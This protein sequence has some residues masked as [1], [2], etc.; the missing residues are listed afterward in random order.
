VKLE[1]IEEESFIEDEKIR[2]VQESY[3]HRNPLNQSS[4]DQ[5]QIGS[6]MLIPKF[7]TK[8]MVDLSDRSSQEN[9]LVCQEH[10]FHSSCVD[11]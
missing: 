3:R 11:L 9:K 10:N 2:R 8:R 5:T 4:T 6:L 1:D 7:V